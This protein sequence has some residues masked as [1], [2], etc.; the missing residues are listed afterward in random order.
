MERH[1]LNRLLFRTASRKSVYVRSPVIIGGFPNFFAI[2]AFNRRGVR[3]DALTI[4][5]WIYVD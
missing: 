5:R 2:Q 3:A 1:P 4:S